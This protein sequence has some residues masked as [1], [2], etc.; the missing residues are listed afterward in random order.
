MYFCRGFCKLFYG[1]LY[2]VSKTV[3]PYHTNTGIVILDHICS[4]LVTNVFGCT[5]SNMMN[6]PDMITEEEQE[7]IDNAFKLVTEEYNKIKL[8]EREI[9]ESQIQEIELDIM[10]IYNEINELRRE[11]KGLECERDKLIRN[12][13]L[14]YFTEK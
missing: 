11:I 3:R 10:K 13:E 2:P 7:I 9:A 5:I 12:I 14:L 6:E 8:K 1:K 4:A